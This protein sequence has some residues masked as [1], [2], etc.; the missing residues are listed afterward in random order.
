LIIFTVP[1]G[2]RAKT[3]GKNKEIPV[4]R[5]EKGHQSFPP[6]SSLSAGQVKQQFRKLKLIS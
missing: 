4:Y 5:R 6:G 1:G 3:P 2:E